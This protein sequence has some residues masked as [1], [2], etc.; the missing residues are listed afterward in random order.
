[1]KSVGARCCKKMKI[2]QNHQAVLNLDIGR[3]SDGQRAHVMDRGFLPLLSPLGGWWVDSWLHRWRNP[4]LRAACQ[5]PA[6][7][8]E[9]SSWQSRVKQPLGLSR[10][11]WESDGSHG[12][13]VSSET[14]SRHSR[15]HVRALT[16]LALTAVDLQ[17]SRGRTPP[18]V[19]PI[20]RHSPE[21]NTKMSKK[22]ASQKA[23]WH[24]LVRLHDD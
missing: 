10:P 12:S 22:N 13:H 15:W 11:R 17:Y 7:R 21:N 23:G 6:Y 3:P 9:L 1:M 18:C 16:T 14:H 8:R 20:S 5:L 4:P 24:H 2:L 19:P